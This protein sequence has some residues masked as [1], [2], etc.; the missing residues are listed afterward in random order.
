VIRALPY[1]CALL[2]GLQWHVMPLWVSL[3]ALLTC[4]YL[5]YTDSKD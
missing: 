1:A 4:A 5:V 3:P 2:L